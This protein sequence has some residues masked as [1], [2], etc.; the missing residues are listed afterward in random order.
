MSARNRSPPT[1]R[2]SPQRYS[3]FSS[4][5]MT[6]RYYSHPAKKTGMLSVPRTMK[7]KQVVRLIGDKEKFDAVWNTG[8]PWEDQKKLEKLSILVAYDKH[9][10][11]RN[12]RVLTITK[13]YGQNIKG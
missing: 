8:L 2:K 7:V 13:S 1:K 3:S 10:I 6:I 4:A 11:G 12:P 5:N 9:K